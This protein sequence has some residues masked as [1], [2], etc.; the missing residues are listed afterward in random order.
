MEN[1]KKNDDCSISSVLDAIKESIKKA[2][3]K[4]CTW[5]TIDEILGF[6][7]NNKDVALTAFTH[8][9]DGVLFSIRNF[10]PDETDVELNKCVKLIERLYSRDIYKFITESS[11][12]KQ[13]DI[14]D[15]L[16][17]PSMTE[18]E[19]GFTDEE[20]GFTDEEK[21]QHIIYK[22]CTNNQKI[23]FNKDDIQ[24]MITKL[25]FG[26]KDE[27]PIHRLRVYKKGKL[28]KGLKFEQNQTSQLLE[29]M[30]YR[31]VLVRV[32]TTLPN[33]DGRNAE[34]IKAIKAAFKEM[35][36]SLVKLVRRLKNHEAFQTMY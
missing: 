29:G 9:T 24:I 34:K 7:D 27:N 28:S 21:L 5:L 3:I 1:I 17:M 12:M 16:R 22:T 26:M 14:E 31:E 13:T 18:E 4:T 15:K 35:W 8:L 19:K 36:S 11:P 25:D 23:S 6:N 33:K 32:Y 30:Q 10:K 2:N 20:K